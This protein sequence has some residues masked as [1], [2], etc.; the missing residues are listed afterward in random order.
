[1]FARSPH[2]RWRIMIFESCPGGPENCAAPEL[3]RRDRNAFRIELSLRNV[4]ST[5]QNANRN[6][7]CA[8]YATFLMDGEIKI[9]DFS[10]SLSLSLAHDTASRMPFPKR[11]LLVQEMSITSVIIFP[12]A[13]QRHH[14]V[15]SLYPPNSTRALLSPVRRRRCS[16]VLVRK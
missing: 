3:C 15:F 12:P 10:L 14:L 11:A 16:A 8:T 2:I 7:E 13:K 5:P 9:H 6:R 4:Q 1:M